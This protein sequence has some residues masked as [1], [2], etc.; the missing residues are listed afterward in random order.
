MEE[1]QNEDDNQSK[2]FF[3]GKPSKSG[4]K[5]LFNVP[6]DK[7]K[8]VDMNRYYKVILVPINFNDE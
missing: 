8:E 6:A 1:S 4:Y 5:V 2:I 3:V 7:R